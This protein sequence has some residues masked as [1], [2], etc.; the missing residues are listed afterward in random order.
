MTQ[1]IHNIIK[2]ATSEDEIVLLPQEA[3]QSRLPLQQLRVQLLQIHL[4]PLR[5]SRRHRI[6]HILDNPPRALTPRPLRRH[7]ILRLQ[8]PVD[9]RCDARDDLARLASAIRRRDVLEWGWL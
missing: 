8:R 6:R 1:R 2:G 4:I 9:Q 3:C 7:R 5:S